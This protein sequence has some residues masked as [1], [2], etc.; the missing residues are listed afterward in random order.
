MI[1]ETRMDRTPGAVMPWG[2]VELSWR[3]TGVGRNELSTE[4]DFMY[5][6][7]FNKCADSDVHG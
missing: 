1:Y 5:F 4:L 3:K 6:I 7:L 2:S